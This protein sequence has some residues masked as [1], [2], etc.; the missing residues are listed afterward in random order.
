MLVMLHCTPCTVTRTSR[1]VTLPRCS[2]SNQAMYPPT[3]PSLRVNLTS[4]M[5]VMLH[6]TPCTV[7]RTL[8]FVTLL[9]RSPSNQ[10]MYPPTAPLE[11]ISPQPCWWC[12]TA[13]PAQWPAR[14]ASSRCQDVLPL[15]S[16]FH[17][18]LPWRHLRTSSALG[19]SWLKSAWRPQVLAR[20]PEWNR[21]SLSSRLR[22]Q[23]SRQPATRWGSGTSTRCHSAADKTAITRSTRSSRVWV[24][25]RGNRVTSRNHYLTSVSLVSVRRYDRATQWK[26]K[27]HFVSSASSTFLVHNLCCDKCI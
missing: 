21:R 5:L 23:L 7:T 18:S 12:Y 2:P 20:R 22:N 11:L 1:F 17:A 9:R 15:R 27:Q 6:C 13:R 8:R 24:R 10:A 4:A 26:S 3:H 14:H 19:P 16:G 25:V